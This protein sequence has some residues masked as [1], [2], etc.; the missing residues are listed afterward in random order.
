MDIGNAISQYLS[1]RANKLD[2]Y[3]HQE[4]N[5]FARAMRAVS[6]SE[7]PID[8]LK[9]P[10]VAAYAEREVANGGDVHARLR[11]VKDFLTY[12]GKKGFHS[13]NLSVHV[14]IPRPSVRGGMAVASS[15]ATFQTMEM[16]QSGLEARK[17]ELADLKGQRPDIVQA[18]RIA[19][20]DKDFRENAPLDAA[21]EEQGKIEARIRDLEEEIR[22]A[23]V[24]DSA[25]GSSVKV[26]ATVSLR[27]LETKRDVTYTIVDTMEADPSSFKI[28]V[29]SPVGA[30]I[31]GKTEGAEVSVQ[32]PKGARKYVI[33]KVKF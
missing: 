33:S 28:S 1:E 31:A 16:T 5:R 10:Q 23:E 21:R 2:S 27:D 22:R 17:K 8:Q 20:A 25:G 3:A 30:A 14:K 26:G 15:R 29:S 7:R 9:A 18:I 11:P 32:T 6:G 13:E 4:L 24:V 12:L 19:A